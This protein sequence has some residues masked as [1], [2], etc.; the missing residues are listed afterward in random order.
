MYGALMP[1]ST[2]NYNVAPGKQ[3]NLNWEKTLFTLFTCTSAAIFKMQIVA[4]LCYLFPPLHSA[5]NEQQQAALTLCVPVIVEPNHWAE[6]LRNR[7][8]RVPSPSGRS[9]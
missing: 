2:Q 3:P 1:R 9:L 5:C 6:T 8:L 7:Q 4:M